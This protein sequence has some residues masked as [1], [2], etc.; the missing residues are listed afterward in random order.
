MLGCVT[1]TVHDSIDMYF[2]ETLTPWRYSL[3]PMKPPART[4]FCLYSCD[5]A[6]TGIAHI[7]LV[8]KFQRTNTDRL[9]TVYKT[10]ESFHV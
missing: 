9:L 4:A 7:Y 1:L 5:K 3:V 2:L 8:H 10:S 6:F